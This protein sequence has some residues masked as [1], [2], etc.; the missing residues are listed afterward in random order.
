MLLICFYSDVVLYVGYLL[1]LGAP[2]VPIWI[3]YIS[4][5]LS[6][7]FFCHWIL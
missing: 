3:N 7:Q 2:S 4:Y 6:G 1:M 5:A